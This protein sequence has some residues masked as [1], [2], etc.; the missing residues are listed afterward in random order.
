MSKNSYTGYIDPSLYAVLINAKSAG[1]VPR[2]PSIKLD[3]PKTVFDKLAKT[4]SHVGK[5]GKLDLRFAASIHERKHFLDLHLSSS[6]WKC[7]LSWFLCT[8]NIF[9]ITNILKNENIKLPLYTIA[10]NLRKDLP[11]TTTERKNVE[12]ICDPIF[13][14]VVDSSIKYM[15][16]VN[17]TILQYSYFTDMY[18]FDVNEQNSFPKQYYYFYYINPLKKFNG[19]LNKAF[20]FY[21]FCS[22]FC[23]DFEEITTVERSYSQKKNLKGIICSLFNKQP[24]ANRVSLELKRDMKYFKHFSKNYV[25]IDSNHSIDMAQFLNKLLSYRRAILSDKDLLVDL[26]GD[27][28]FMKKWI[29]NE[30]VKTPYIVDFGR[31]L[32]PD[33]EITTNY[34]ASKW[35]VPNDQFLYY[36]DNIGVKFFELD[37][38]DNLINQQLLSSYLVS[39]C[40]LFPFKSRIISEEFLE[41]KF[42]DER[43]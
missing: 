28:N 7:L 24:F 12:I 38:I 11:L 30:G 25:R 3:N 23:N 42:C 20:S 37:D 14:N 34:S 21:N 27:I 9:Q 36:S 39:P 6:L 35:I 26:L 43:N 13:E 41:F 33:T 1:W 4:S 5:D 40:K 18:S 22:W 10:G 2:P 15:I 19:D 29:A 31:A 8:A 17:G 32:S 16:E